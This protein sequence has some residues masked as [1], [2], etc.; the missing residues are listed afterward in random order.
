MMLDAAADADEVHARALCGFA[1]DP[2]V[3]DVDGAR[4]VDFCAIEA[5]AQDVWRRLGANLVERARDRIEYAVE[6]EMLDQRRH[7]RRAIGRQPELVALFELEHEG[8]Q[9]ERRQQHFEERRLI[10]VARHVVHRAELRRVAARAS[11]EHFARGVRNRGDFL[12]A[13][14]RRFADLRENPVVIRNVR[15]GGI[16]QHAVGVEHHKFNHV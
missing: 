13:V 10:H 16:E 5:Q 8:S 12:V 9:L 3:A 14:E 6:A 1:I 7:G 15:F 4:R 11:G 2:A